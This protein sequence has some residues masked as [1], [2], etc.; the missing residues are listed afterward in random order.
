MPDGANLMSIPGAAAPISVYCMDGYVL[1]AKIDGS[2]PTWQYS[3][4]L[5]Y[6]N[7]STLNPSNLSTTQA[8]AKLAAFNTFPV[9]SFRVIL[10]PLG[11]GAMGNKLEVSLRGSYASAAAVFATKP[12]TIKTSIGRAGWK[13]W[14][15]P[16][17]SL[18]QHCNAEGINV[19]TAPST[20][21]NVPTYAAARIG[22]LGN[23]VGGCTDPDSALGVGLVKATTQWVNPA[24]S[25]GSA[26][27][28]PNCPGKGNPPPGCGNDHGNTAQPFFVYLLGGSGEAAPQ[29]PRPSPP[30]SPPPPPSPKPPKPKPPPPPK[31]RTPV[32]GRKT[33]M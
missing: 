17:A 11:G 18:Q 3:S 22:L 33:K 25:A 29:P 13:A 7:I 19:N 9:S 16:G 20:V 1:L 30:P 23:D 8:E 12:N 5:W 31:H 10:A 15:G 26:P 24:V 14:I 21:P 27:A 2:K 4:S 32:F 28:G 6:N